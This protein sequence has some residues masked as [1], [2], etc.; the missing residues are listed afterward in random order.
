[1]PE[2]MTAEDARQRAKALLGGATACVPIQE[3]E[4]CDWPDA[5][6]G[7]AVM[8]T[9]EMPAPQAVALYQQCKRQRSDSGLSPLIVTRAGYEDLRLREWLAPG[10]L[11]A[12]NL[13][14]ARAAYDALTAD[15]FFASRRE[16]SGRD[17]ASLI[18][19]A[20]DDLGRVAGCDPMSILHRIRIGDYRVI[21]AVERQSLVV[22]VVNI[23]N[24][25][26]IYR[27]F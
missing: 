4:A 22:L 5:L 26:D 13:A 23:G 11:A 27:S 15:Q 10:P 21:Y 14:S 2:R 16:A 3:L 9:E 1:M 17:A 8:V 25:R 19:E 18:E 6:A 20:L 7:M 24:R 12:A